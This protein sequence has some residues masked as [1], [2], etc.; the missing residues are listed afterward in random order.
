MRT[1]NALRWVA[2]GCAFFLLLAPLGERTYWERGNQNWFYRVYDNTPYD[3]L[4]LLSGVIAL[5]GL[6][7]TVGECEGTNDCC[8][9]L[10]CQDAVPGVSLGAC[11]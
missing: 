5:A 9:S 10:T 8:G 3:F 4:A 11:G 2:L 7:W 1:E 6:Y